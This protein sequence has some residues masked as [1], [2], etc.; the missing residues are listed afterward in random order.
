MELRLEPL[1]PRDCPAILFTLTDTLRAW[2]DN[3]QIWQQQ[4]FPGFH[5]GADLAA[6]DVTGDGIPDAIVGAGPGGGPHVK[7]LNGL[8]GAEVASFYAYDEAFRGGVYVGFGGPRGR[9]ATGAGPG[10]GPH[11]QVFEIDSGNAVAVL[12]YFAGDPSTRGGVRVSGGIVEQQR[13][14]SRPSAPI[15]IYL[16]FADR[17]ELIPRVYQQVADAFA[18]F[19]V[20]VTTIQPTGPATTWVS[21]VVGPARGFAAGDVP[22]EARGVAVVD[23][24]ARP[25]PFRPATAYVFS[26]RIAT[27]TQLGRAVAHEAAHLF[28]ADHS[29]DPDSIM[30]AG[31]SVGTGSFDALNT[32]ILRT[33]LGVAK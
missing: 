28:G 20:N 25:D 10:G 19:N 14:E 15:A 8:D 27:V 4:P 30:F 29:A 9:V 18:Q 33:R 11:V 5:G 22:A 21:V 6:G 7:V 13:L 12:S 1:E 3:V 23:A 16:S 31:L 17:I 2:S 26:D 32:V 24:F